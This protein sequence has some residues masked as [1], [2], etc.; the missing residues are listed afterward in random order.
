VTQV[1]HKAEA[2]GTQGGGSDRLGGPPHDQGKNH[3]GVDGP[4]MG[5]QL[6]PREQRRW[7]QRRPKMPLVVYACIVIFIRICSSCQRAKM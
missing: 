2:K 5:L 4:P 6:R 1:S 3:R 7:R